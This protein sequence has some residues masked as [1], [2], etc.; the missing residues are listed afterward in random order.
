MRLLLW[1]LLA[2]LLA[3]M[4]STNATSSKLFNPD[5]TNVDSTFPVPAAYAGYDGK[6]LR[7]LRADDTEVAVN[8]D[9]VEEERA[10]S[11]SNILNRASKSLKTRLSARAQKAIDFIVERLFIYGYNGGGNT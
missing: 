8:S 2:T 3:L 9:S 4:S 11:I 1:L 5:A 10:F 7:R 6:R